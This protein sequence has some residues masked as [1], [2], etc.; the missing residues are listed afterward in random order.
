MS[1]RTLFEKIWDAHVVDSPLQ[2]AARLEALKEAGV[3]AEPALTTHRQE[4]LYIKL[5]PHRQEQLDGF[6]CRLAPRRH[7]VDTGR[8]RWHL[9][10]SGHRSFSP[11]MRLML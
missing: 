3:N 8:R 10:G 6:G 2:E 11:C 1:G 9:D 7:D 4:L 5:P